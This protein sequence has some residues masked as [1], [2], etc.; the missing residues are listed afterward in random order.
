MLFKKLKKNPFFFSEKWI[1]VLPIF[2]LMNQ[3][4]K[5]A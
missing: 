3:M 5:E 1:C 2:K 4:N